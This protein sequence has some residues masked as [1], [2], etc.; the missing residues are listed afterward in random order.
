MEKTRHE[1]DFTF[2]PVCTDS[3]LASHILG[4]LETAEQANTTQPVTVEEER[5]LE[6]AHYG[7]WTK[8]RAEHI[9]QVIQ[10]A[11][12]RMASLETAFREASFIE[13][14]HAN[15][16][17]NAFVACESRKSKLLNMILVDGLVP[18]VTLPT[19]AISLLKPSYLAY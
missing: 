4:L 7:L 19:A 12:S 9:E 1:E 6:H 14:Q 2:Q 15:A 8:T 13:E 10:V 18:S 11:R 3:N 17:D 16:I 5:E